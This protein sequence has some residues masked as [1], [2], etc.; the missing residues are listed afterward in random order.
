[1]DTPVITAT[2]EMGFVITLDQDTKIAPRE[3][4]PEVVGVQFGGT[5]DPADELDV[6]DVGHGPA[7]VPAVDAGIAEEGS[8]VRHVERCRLERPG[9]GN[10]A[11][12][13]VVRAHVVGSGPGCAGS[14]C[15][16]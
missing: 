6:G 2:W 15:R 13:G 12:H 3:D 14:I 16:R 11:G 4:A 10:E 5:V 7:Q 8:R 9:T 1:M